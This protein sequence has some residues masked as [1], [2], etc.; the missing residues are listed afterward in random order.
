[1]IPG[2]PGMQQSAYSGQQQP[3][4]QMFLGSYGTG[5]GQVMLP[6][7]QQQ[8]AYGGNLIGGMYENPS[9]NYEQSQRPGF[10]R[11]YS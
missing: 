7:M 1:M 3:T 10:H 5:G 4:G 8:P 6:W 9:Y 2:I 11:T